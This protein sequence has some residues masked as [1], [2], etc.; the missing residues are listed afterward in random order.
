MGYWKK[1]ALKAEREKRYAESSAK[2]ANCLREEQ[3]DKFA[4]LTERDTYQAIAIETILEENRKLRRQHSAD[5]ERED[6]LAKEIEKLTAQLN[7]MRALA[8]ALK[9]NNVK[10]WGMIH[11]ARGGQ[12]KQEGGATA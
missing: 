3:K 2:L 5:L 4:E 11:A 10:L 1:R 9:A 7:A 8:D 6:A 12:Q